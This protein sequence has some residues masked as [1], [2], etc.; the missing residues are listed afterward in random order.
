M[1][2]FVPL[3]ACMILITV[4]LAGCTGTQ[5]AT[6]PVQTTA[7]GS[8]TVAATPAESF[9]LGASY[10]SHPTP[11]S[12][13]SEKDLYT[14]QFRATNEPWGVEF[15]VNPTNEDPQYTWFKIKLTQMDTGKTDTF[16]YG[17]EFAYDKYQLH[18]M[19]ASG[20]YKVE[21]TGNRVSV[22]VDIAKI[23]P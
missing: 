2:A 13:T 22:R 4:L 23:K 16:G 14:E 17:R 19:Y 10:L 15:T 11:Y 8:P 5:T 12:F 20:P 18:R 6:P 1:K 21:M 7:A 9:E 3:L